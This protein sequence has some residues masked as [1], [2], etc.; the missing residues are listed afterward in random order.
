MNKI[1]GKRA[2]SEDLVKFEVKSPISEKV[3]LPGQYIILRTEE[4][5][6]EFILPVLKTDKERGTITIA[7][8]NTDE[9]TRQL[10]S[11]NI[12][13]EI[14]GIDGP[15]GNPAKIENSGAVLCICRGLGIL[16]YHPILTSL[17]AAG[18][19]IVTVLSAQTKEKIILEAEIKSISDEVIILTD[20]GNYGEKE[21]FC[22]AVSKVLRNSRFD[23]V[24]TIGCAKTLK[25]TFALTQKYNIPT[26]ATLYLRKTSENRLNGIFNVNICG[27]AKSVCVDGLNFNAYYQSF[28]EMAKRFGNEY[29]DSVCMPSVPKKVSTPV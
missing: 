26:Q 28:E 20:D 13:N 18:N 15:Y 3:I 25:E 11:L 2:V 9:N 4:N 17:R 24:Y 6:A 14:L 10:S 19:R 12:G 5:N 22:H 1:I 23:Q 7:V 8:Q 27:S 29:L 16:F 21:S